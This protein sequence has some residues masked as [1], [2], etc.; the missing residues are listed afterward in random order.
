VFCPD[1]GLL[2]GRHRSGPRT[3]FM[4]ECLADLDRALRDRGG[5]LFLRHGSPQRELRELAQEL[6][7]RDVHFTADVGPFARRRQRQVRDALVEV[8]VKIVAHPGLFAVDQLD[9]IRTTAGSPYTVFTPFYRSWL[10]QRV[11]TCSARRVRS[12]PRLA[13]SPR[14][15]CRRSSSSAC[16]RGAATRW[17]V[18]SGPAARRCS[19]F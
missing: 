14:A 17:R 12:R 15:S 2:K 19:A 16:S 11:A 7:A 10:G 3:Q 5:R 9:S 4:L 6:G 1:D 18:V 8:D 13:A